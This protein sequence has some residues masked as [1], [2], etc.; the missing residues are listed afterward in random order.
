MNLLMFTDSSTDTEM[1]RK[2]LPPPQKSVTCPVSCVTCHMSH[3]NDVLDWY[4]LS[5]GH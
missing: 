3:D 5:I 2:A 4:F 1:D